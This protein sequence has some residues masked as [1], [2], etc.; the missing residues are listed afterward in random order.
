MRALV[1][2]VEMTAAGLDRNASLGMEFPEGVATV[3]ILADA[4]V[5]DPKWP[6]PAKPTPKPAKH[7][8]I[9]TSR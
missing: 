1:D 5:P 8:G 4:G 9:A 6:S 2:S 3:A 7:G